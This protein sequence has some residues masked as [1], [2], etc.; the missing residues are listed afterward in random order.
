MY[1]KKAYILYRENSMTVNSLGIMKGR[2][3]NE[4]TLKANCQEGWNF[5]Y[6]WDFLGHEQ[7]SEDQ[8]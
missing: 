6:R 4:I 1:M 7:K 8:F 3:M 5:L 2:G